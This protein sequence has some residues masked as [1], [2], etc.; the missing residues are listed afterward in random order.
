MSGLEIAGL[1]VAGATLGTQLFGLKGNSY[2]AVTTTTKAS[3]LYVYTSL[4]TFT[5][6]E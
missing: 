3:R 1:A 2:Q 6:T 5:N 4:D